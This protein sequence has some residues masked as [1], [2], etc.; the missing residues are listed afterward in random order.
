MTNLN[1]LMNIIGDRYGTYNPF[2]IAD[3][4]N[5][6][7]YWKDFFPRPYAETLYYGDEPV[8]M[9]SNAIRESPER[10]YVLGHELGHVII[11]DG[12][13]A[14]YI[15]NNKFRSKSES[16]ADKFALGLMTNLFNEENGRVP[17]SYNELRSMY[18]TP[19]LDVNS[20]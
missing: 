13:T 17:Y 18:G 10:Y 9:L 7:V 11:H 12:L 1:E 2:T 3:K 6:D 5:I 20:I 15:A 4:L 19:S 14:Y 8:V 16:E